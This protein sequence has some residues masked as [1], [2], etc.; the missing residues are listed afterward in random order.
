[1]SD[2]SRGFLAGAGVLVAVLVVGGLAGIFR[3]IV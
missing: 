1:M 2:F 3:R